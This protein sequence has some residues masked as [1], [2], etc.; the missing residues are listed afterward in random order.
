MED[1]LCTAALRVLEVSEK[2]LTSAEI[3]AALQMTPGSERVLAGVTAERFRAILR[4]RRCHTRDRGLFRL[5]HKETM[6]AA[7]VDLRTPSSDLETHLARAMQEVTPFDPPRET[8]FGRSTK[9]FDFKAITPDGDTHV[10]TLHTDSGPQDSVF[11]TPVLLTLEEVET[12][13]KTAF[14]VD[15]PAL[16]TY[17]VS[18]C[19]PGHLCISFAL[20]EYSSERGTKHN[21]LSLVQPGP[22]YAAG[23]MQVLPT[24]AIVVNGLSGSVQMN[25]LDEQPKGWRSKPLPL[26]TQRLP[27]FM[28][29]RF[30]GATQV[31]FPTNE[32]VESR[33]KESGTGTVVYN[34]QVPLFDSHFVPPPLY[35]RGDLL[36][37]AERFPDGIITAQGFSM[38]R[39]EIR[40]QLRFARGQVEAWRKRLASVTGTGSLY[41]AKRSMMQKRLNMY[42][43]KIAD[44]TRDRQVGGM[45]YPISV[46]EAA[47]ILRFS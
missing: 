8:T 16:F 46:A 12:A 1:Q 38:S 39:S 43:D 40:L 44:L 36:R 42:L 11:T 19:T 21:H 17:L 4:G 28:V 23:E 41:D 30:F 20:R 34:E 13:C 47:A 15:A 33:V 7:S 14:V 22:L 31:L 24:G 37:A 32:D 5:L 2:P 29:A 25:I 26:A 18:E 3:Y 35:T 27:A 45:S 10:L 6:E 9:A